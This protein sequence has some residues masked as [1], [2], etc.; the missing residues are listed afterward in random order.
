MP[1][2]T[3]AEDTRRDAVVCVLLSTTR[4]IFCCEGAG[5]GQS[6]ACRDAEAPSRLSH[7]RVGSE[8]VGT[9]FRRVRGDDDEARDGLVLVEPGGLEPPTSALQRRRSPS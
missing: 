5:G 8:A 2:G 3:Y 9:S 6:P 7:S 4:A 1:R